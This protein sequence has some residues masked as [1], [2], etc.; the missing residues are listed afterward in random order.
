MFSKLRFIPKSIDPN[1]NEYDAYIFVRNLSTLGIVSITF[2]AFF[3]L[4]YVHNIPV[5]IAEFITA[6]GF[7]FINIDLIKNV[8]VKRSSYLFVIFLTLLLLFY[9]LFADK[10]EYALVWNI[11]P[12]ITMLYLF[13]AKRGA[14]FSAIYFS[15][16]ITYLLSIT[17]EILS[18]RS[19][20]NLLLNFIVVSLGILFY[21]N[22]RQKML[23]NVNSLVEIKERQKNEL[24]VLSQTDTLTKVANRLKLDQVLEHEFQRAKRYNTPLTLV[25]IDI[26]YFKNV[27]DNYGHQAG[28]TVLQ[29][30]SQLI[31]N[32]IRVTDTFGRWGGE[33]FLLILPETSSAQG[34]NLANQL[35]ESV[36]QH[37]FSYNFSNTASFG[38]SSFQ[39]GIALQTL[40]KRADKALYQAKEQ[41]RNRVVY[42]QNI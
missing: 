34:V 9:A 6:I 18:I 17:P 16:L 35:C 3:N 41:G 20:I 12:V 8:N 10:S 19:S 38:V 7:T 27:N 30:F 29:E 42:L 5:A 24:L 4:F 32:S 2:F 26:D 22:S 31:E 14:I 21:E 37:E 15:I 36:A 13:G 25:F 11:L 28:D 1:S 39:Q 40:I 33:E 23:Q